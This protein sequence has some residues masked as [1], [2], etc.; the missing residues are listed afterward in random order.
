MSQNVDL[1]R[2]IFVVLLKNRIYTI[3]SYVE[4]RLT[5]YFKTL[6]EECGL[7]LFRKF[8]GN[9]EECDFRGFCNGCILRG[10]IG[11]RKKGGMCK[12]YV[13]KVSQNLKQMLLS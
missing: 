9:Q 13:K 4:K 11:F 6:G 7:G 5:K 1:S 2:F 8:Q 10:I 12:W 3:C